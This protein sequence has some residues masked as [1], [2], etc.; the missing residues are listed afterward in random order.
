MKLP[1]N[2]RHRMD[3]EREQRCA[4]LR[5]RNSLSNTG[6]LGHVRERLMFAAS[7]CP[8]REGRVLYCLP[9]AFKTM[10]NSLLRLR[11]RRFAPTRYDTCDKTSAYERINSPRDPRE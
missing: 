9:N 4:R 10:V 2:H 6:A 3:N 8:N 5:S 1:S 7:T 11:I